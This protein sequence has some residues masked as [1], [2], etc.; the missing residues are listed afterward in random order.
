M[1]KN[2]LFAFLCLL[3]TF[4][5]TAQNAEL[6]I[7]TGHAASIY[8]MSISPDGQYLLTTDVVHTSIF[9]DAVT[10]KQLHIIPKTLAAEF[11]PDN[12]TFMV[13]TTDAY[14]LTMD[15]GGNV[16]KVDGENTFKVI[17]LNTQRQRQQNYC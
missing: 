16:P 14:V 17:T 13:V 6:M 11:S 7:Q 9:W 1:K 3:F 5:I 4:K 15:Y 12:K 10:K 2:L 8:S